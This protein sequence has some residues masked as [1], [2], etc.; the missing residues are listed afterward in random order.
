MFGVE[1]ERLGEAV[2]VAIH[3]VP[4]ST[5]DQAGLTEHLQP[6]LAKFK[7]PDHVFFMDA[8]LPQNANGKFL[9]RQL[10]EQLAPSAD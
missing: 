5:L 4:D 3:L 9:K 1:D 2:G 10:R 6:R 7:I 8:P